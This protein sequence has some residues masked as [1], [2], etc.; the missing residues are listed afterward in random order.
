VAGV[1]VRVRL[2]E[3]DGQRKRIV[4]LDAASKNDGADSGC[5]LHGRGVNWAKCRAQL[6]ELVAISADAWG[7]PGTRRGPA[8]GLNSCGLRSSHGQAQ[9]VVVEGLGQAAGTAGRASD[10]RRGREGASHRQSRPRKR[11]C[12]GCVGVALQQAALFGWR[13]DIAQRVVD[14][15]YGDARRLYFRALELHEQGRYEE[16]EELY[17]SSGV[18]R[19][20]ASIWMHALT[21]MSAAVLAAEA[22]LL[23]KN[24]RAWDRAFTSGM[25]ELDGLSGEAFE[26]RISGL[27][28]SLGYKTE[29]TKATED[30]G[31]DIIALRRQKTTVVH[32]KHQAA[33][34]GVEAIQK[35]IAS[36]QHYE[37][38]SALVVTNSTF[39]PQ[40]REL[41]S[42][43]GVDLWDR[44]ALTKRLEEAERRRKRRRS[45]VRRAALPVAAPEPSQSN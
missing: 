40:A 24:R 14:E 8:Q 38:S 17:D 36:R 30:A 42:R 12:T 1:V 45:R 10:S 18:F 11:P 44:A 29:I 27:L 16:L 39:T 9:P 43:A 26:S 3:A 33:E 13:R 2:D 31:G 32:T 7:G 20:S 5:L 21:R 41:A 6:A 28:R 35:A 37:A 19:S 4:N 15:A 23:E 25:P 34:V 22:S